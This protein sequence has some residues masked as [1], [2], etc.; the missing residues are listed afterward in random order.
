MT[1][2]T[3]KQLQLTLDEYTDEWI[4]THHP[5]ERTA[6]RIERQKLEEELAYKLASQ[7]IKSRWRL[8]C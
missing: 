2:L 8:S 3:I 4:N 5:A 7:P 6:L 1:S